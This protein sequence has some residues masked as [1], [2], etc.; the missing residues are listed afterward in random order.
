MGHS[1]LSLAVCHTR[2]S[3]EISY[4]YY[5][6]MR[7][8]RLCAYNW[9]LPAA[10]SWA[11]LLTI[12]VWSF[13]TYNCSFFAYNWGFFAYNLA[14]FTYSEKVGLISTRMNCKQRGATASKKAPTVMKNLPPMRYIGRDPSCYLSSLKFLMLL[15]FNLALENE[16]LWSG[17]CHRWEVSFPA[18]H[19]PGNNKFA[20]CP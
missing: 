6:T 10:Y 8:M 9:K 15:I 3:V 4:W 12:V 20:A 14:F 13:F 17:I 11:S 2:R 7:W 19:L 16:H 18:Y 1:R 5:S